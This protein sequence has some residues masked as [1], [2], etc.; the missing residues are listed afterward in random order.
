MAKILVDTSIIVDFLRR[1]DK[2]KTLLFRL[3]QDKHQLCAS[4]ITH[5]ESFAGKSVW[6]KRKAAS[7]LEVLFSGISL[8]PLDEKVSKKAGEIRAY[9]NISLLDAIIAAASIVHQ[10]KLVTLNVKD[11]EKIDKINLLKTKK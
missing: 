11:F 3:I 9:H 2:K 8:L 10:L 6:E 1:K 5:T 7:E 4:I